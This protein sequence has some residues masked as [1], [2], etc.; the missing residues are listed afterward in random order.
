[1]NI[2]GCMGCIVYQK[3]FKVNIKCDGCM[4]AVKLNDKREGK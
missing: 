2:I 4:M 1:M 3:I